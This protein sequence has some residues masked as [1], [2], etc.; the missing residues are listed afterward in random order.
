MGDVMTFADAMRRAPDLFPWVCLA[1]VLVFVYTQRN[2]I[3]EYF[4]ARIDAHRARSKS[5]AVM[6][7]LVRMNTA[8]VENVKSALENSTAALENNSAAFNNNTA[9]LSILQQERRDMVT[10]L[11]SHEQLSGER[12][13]HVQTVVNRIDETVRQNNNEISLI[14]DRTK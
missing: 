12:I 9:M 3:V 1:L 6:E 8:T 11:E 2:R 7:E 5:D 10:L 4:D 14:S 13:A